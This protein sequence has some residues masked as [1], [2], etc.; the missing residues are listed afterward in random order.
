MAETATV[1][2]IRKPRRNHQKDM[3]DLR[4]YCEAYL[5]ILREVTSGE[6]ATDREEGQRIALQHVLAR[7]GGHDYK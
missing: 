6:A 5:D 2:R 3:E 4:T 1:K 7:L